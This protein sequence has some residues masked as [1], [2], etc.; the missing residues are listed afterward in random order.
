M[1]GGKRRHARNE[2]RTDLRRK[3]GAI[4]STR[5]HRLLLAGNFLQDLADDEHAEAHR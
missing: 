1:R 3:R 2:F 4:Q 5:S